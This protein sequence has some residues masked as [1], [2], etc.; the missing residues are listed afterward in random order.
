MMTEVESQIRQQ[1]EILFKE[2]QKLF[3]LRAEQADLIGA[4]SGTISA[5]RNL[6]ATINKL[7]QEKQRQQE[8]LYKSEFQIAQMERTV[9][10]LMG[11]R[12]MEDQKRIQ[13]EIEDR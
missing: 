12:S 13:A 6:Q 7:N 8:L 4:I 2:S 10:R 9:A 5:K 11:E 3:K 1:K